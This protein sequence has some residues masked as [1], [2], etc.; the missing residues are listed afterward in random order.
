MNKLFTS[1]ELICRLCLGTDW[2]LQTHPVC[3]ICTWKDNQHCLPP[4]QQFSHRDSSQTKSLHSF[5]GLH[6]CLHNTFNSQKTI[7]IIMRHLMN[8]YKNYQKSKF[9]G[10]CEGDLWRTTFHYIQSSKW[11]Y[12]LI[13]YTQV[14]RELDTNLCK[15]KI[16]FYVFIE[17]W[18]LDTVQIE[19]CVVPLISIFRITANLRVTDS[20]QVMLLMNSI[21]LY[22]LNKLNVIPHESHYYNTSVALSEKTE[23]SLSME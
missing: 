23:V 10:Q 7:K 11:Y 19:N 22:Y 1:P 18:G 20:S 8:K 16:Y 21:I 6:S 17:Q 5:C 9:G 15:R 3:Y 12:R 2:Q 14:L 13:V 4:G